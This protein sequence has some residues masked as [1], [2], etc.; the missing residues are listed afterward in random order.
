MTSER[1]EKKFYTFWEEKNSTPF[2]RKR[3][4]EKEA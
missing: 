2:F 3:N 4:I 1:R